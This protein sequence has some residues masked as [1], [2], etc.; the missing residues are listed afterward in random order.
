MQL[1]KL[2]EA[3]M[4]KAYVLQTA[5][6]ADEN[7][8]VNLAYGYSFDQFIHYVQTRKGYEYGIGLP[9]GF[10]PDTVFVLVNDEGEYVGLFNFRHTL[11][12][13]LRAGPGHVGFGIAPSFRRRGYASEGLRLLIERI[14]PQIAEDEIY[15][16]VHKDNPASLRAMQNNGGMIHHEIEG[17]FCVRIPKIL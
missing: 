8:F 9:E 15:L 10:V 14:S 16:S 3:D 1:V 6:E 7:G 2:W 4:K 5:F 13:F 12:D 17:A 11:N